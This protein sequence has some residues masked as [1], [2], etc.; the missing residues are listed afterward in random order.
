M[1]IIEVTIKDFKAI[2]N[3]KEEIKGCNVFLRGENGVGKSSF[4]QFI[5]IALGKTSIV[6][7]NTN[8]EGQVITDKEGRIYKFDVKID[9]K[10]GKPKVT[11]TLPEGTR[12]TAKSVIA[13]I[14][15]LNSF[16]IDN[17][18]NLSLTE[19]GRK[20]Q[21]EEFK[22]FLDEETRLALAKWE[23][24]AK[25]NYDDRTEVNRDITK[26]KG[27]IQLHPMINHI[28]ELDRFT[29]TKT[30]SVLAELKTIQA[31]NEKVTKVLANIEQRDKDIEKATKEIEDLK[32]K[33]EVYNTEI[34]DKI[35]LTNQ[36]NVWLKEHKI[37]PVSELEQTIKDASDNNL[38]WTGAQSLKLEI[39]KQKVLEDESGDLTV[40]IDAAKEAIRLAIQEMEGPVE[41]L[42][43]DEDQLLYNGIPVHP[44]SLSKSEIKKLGIRLKIAENPDLPLFIHEAEC[45]GT[46]SLKEIQ[47]LAAECG[48][49]MF[50]EEV[51]RGEKQLQ[52]EIQPA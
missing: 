22:K 14:V 42:S 33:I 52:V 2:K 27:S 17:F 20:K 29:E 28:H 50:A 49:Q 21:V 40:R 43:F 15:G 8:I 30:E 34:N 41:G 51:K 24:N 46:D 19:A 26:L 10:S 7:P 47:D 31:H 35:E 18:V 25:T 48:L 12:D 38:K 6:P 1:N 13:G 16:D 9:S 39:E 45:M 37:K 3:L 23:A 36:A 44:S 4:M 5:E 11:V 32:A